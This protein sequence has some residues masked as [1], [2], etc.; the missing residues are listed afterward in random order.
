MPQGG[1][2]DA[3]RRG[4]LCA[5]GNVSGPAGLSFKTPSGGLKLSLR[6]DRLRLP[7]AWNRRKAR[8]IL[9]T[10]FSVSR[11][12]SRFLVRVA[13]AYQKCVDFLSGLEE[14]FA[15]RLPPFSPRQ[16]WQ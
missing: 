5:G 6:A 8:P 9:I 11:A 1:R 2:G 10:P 16:D 13:S 14:V 7:V 3:E 15:L 4:G 12:V